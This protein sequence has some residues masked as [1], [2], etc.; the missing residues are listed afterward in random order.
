M[1][2]G[3]DDSLWLLRGDE[4]SSPR[5]PERPCDYVPAWLSTWIDRAAAPD[6]V[7]PQ[8]DDECIVTQRPLTDG[9]WV[10]PSPPSP[11]DRLELGQFEL[12]IPHRHESPQS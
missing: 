12:A 2:H 6:S 4:G 3:C 7:Y 11:Q 1:C 5:V 9:R 10:P 8:S